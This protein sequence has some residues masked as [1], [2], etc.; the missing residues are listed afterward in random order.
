MLALGL[1]GIERNKLKG[2]DKTMGNP[3]NLAEFEE[4]FFKNMRGL[5]GSDEVIRKRIDNYY[6]LIVLRDKANPYAPN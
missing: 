5:S 1:F 2:N 4:L 3:K 6:E